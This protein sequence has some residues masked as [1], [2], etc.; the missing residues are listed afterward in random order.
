MPTGVDAT[1]LFRRAAQAGISLA[2]GRIFT[3]HEQ[4]HNC[5]RLSYGL[6]F[7]EE[8][9][10]GLIRLAGLIREAIALAQPPNQDGRPYPLSIRKPGLAADS[11]TPPPHESIEMV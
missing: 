4:Y 5:F 10:A 6:P 11:P 3:L 9:E 8:V 2:P 1:A 7:N